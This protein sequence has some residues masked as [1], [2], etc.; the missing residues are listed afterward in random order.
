MFEDY[1]L[2]FVGDSDIA[3]IPVSVS[4]SVLLDSLPSGNDLLFKDYEKT[5]WIEKMGGQATKIESRRGPWG[6]H[7]VFLDV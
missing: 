1:N 4:Q 2:L 3:W 6:R 5:A 7:S